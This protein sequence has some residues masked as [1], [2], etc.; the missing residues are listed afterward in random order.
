MVNTNASET[1]RVGVIGGSGL[2]RL[3]DQP[4]LVEVA[5]PYGPP[6]SHVAVGTF[7]DRTV[8]F[9]AR[10]GTGH[11]VPPQRINYRANL[12]ALASLGVRSVIGSSAV[13]S[14]TPEMP[15]DTFVVPDQLID[16]TRDRADTYFDGAD[17]QH[18]GFADPFDPVVRS[19]L[20][21]ALRRR[22][23][24]FVPVGTT[25]VIPGPRFSTRAESR[26]W[27]LLGA[28]ILNMTQYPESAL[29]AELGM[30]YASLSFVT[31]A[32]VGRAPDDEAVSAE[33]VFQRLSAAQD[34]IIG[35]IADAIR[36][37]PAEPEPRALVDPA[38]T[39][40][41]LTLTVAP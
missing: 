8:A 13:G 18:L 41:V 34:R 22:G 2:Y 23:E 10:H 19:A 6:S 36:L 4:R 24:S 12:W 31:D 1:P 20:C 14:I 35:T 32:D 39:A 29:A 17:V 21:D 25:L 28:D 30:G 26:A 3:L 40:R 15:A 27:R 38:A 7:A 33:V 16:R 5:T 9:L 37:L 11:T